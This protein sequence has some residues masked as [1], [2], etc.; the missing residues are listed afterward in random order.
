VFLC[1]L[2]QILQAAGCTQSLLALPFEPQNRGTHP[3]TGIFLLYNA[4]AQVSEPCWQA[5]WISSSSSN[6][7][8]SASASQ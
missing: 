2:C 8:A 5:L 7:T 6:A 4:L 3:I 1:T